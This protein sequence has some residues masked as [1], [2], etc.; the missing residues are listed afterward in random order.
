MYLIDKWYKLYISKAWYLIYITY[1][2]NKF[3]NFEFK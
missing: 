3:Y 1:K 2:S